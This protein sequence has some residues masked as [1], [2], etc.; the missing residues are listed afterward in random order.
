MLL[1]LILLSPRT[2]RGAEKAFESIR[3]E[4]RDRRFRC[5]M[6]KTPG[7]TLERLVT[8]RRVITMA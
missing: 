1:I 6:D 4:Q 2:M 8:S 3:S 7:A 5:V